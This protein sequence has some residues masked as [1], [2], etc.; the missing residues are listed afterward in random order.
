MTKCDVTIHVDKAD[1]SFV[2]GER[3]RGH[4]TVTTDQQVRCD[5]LT[6]MLQWRTHGRGNRANGPESTVKLHEGEWGGG[7]QHAYAFE[8]IAPSGPCSYHGT[9]VNVD[10]YLEARVDLPWAVDPK[11]TAEVLLTPGPAS[12]EYDFG[13]A[14][15]P[16]AAEL[17]S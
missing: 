10:H 12:A 7:E 17:Q 11:A 9:H 3:I 6:V 2:P 8:F 1:R 13:P 5:A 14:Y 16:P 15:K 4:V